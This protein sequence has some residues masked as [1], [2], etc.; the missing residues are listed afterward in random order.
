MVHVD[1]VSL[2]AFS[3]YTQCYAQA[4]HGIPNI[5]ISERSRIQ[6]PCN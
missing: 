6:K 1:W 4:H 2:D 5:I 3:K